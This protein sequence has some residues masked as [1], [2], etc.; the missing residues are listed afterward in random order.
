[1]MVRGLMLLTMVA[2]LTIVGLYTTELRD[3]PRTTAGWLIVPATF[4][5]AVRRF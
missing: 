5:M 3:Y 1:M 2:V 4:T